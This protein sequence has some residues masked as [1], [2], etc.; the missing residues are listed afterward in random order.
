MLQLTDAIATVLAESEVPLTCAEIATVVWERFPELCTIPAKLNSEKTPFDALKADIHSRVKANA[1][2]FKQN[3]STSPIQVS[4][5]GTDTAWT[6]E[7][8][9][10]SVAAYLEMWELAMAGLPFVKMD[11]YRGLAEATG[12]SVGAFERRMQNIS[13]VFSGVGR[14]PIPGLVPLPNIGS[15][16]AAR[17][18]LAIE[19][20]EGKPL[21]P[22]RF[23]LETSPRKKATLEAPPTGVRRP[24]EET[25]SATRF[26][27]DPRV[28]DWVLDAAGGYCESCSQPAPFDGVYGPFLEVHHVRRLASQ[29]SDTVSNAVA[30]CPNCHRRLHFGL[31]A[32]KLVD[33]LYSKISRLQ[34]E[35]A[36]GLGPDATRSIPR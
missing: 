4:L 14:M 12:R 33:A 10:A 32:A 20:Q 24:Q 22:L 26:V 28:R 23:N 16:V 25:V 21:E 3:K 1:R 8:L 15:K 27:R 11:Y 9:K 6:D 19:A 17:I 18:A 7:E 30:L 35:S 13:S 31:D 29:G 2:R 34:R 5:S 36:S